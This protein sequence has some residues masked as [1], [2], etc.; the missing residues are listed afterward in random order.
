[1]PENAWDVSRSPIHVLDDMSDT[2]CQVL[3]FGEMLRQV[4]TMLMRWLARRGW[5]PS[6]LAALSHSH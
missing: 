5:M 1:M 6:R 4:G 3:D 2:L